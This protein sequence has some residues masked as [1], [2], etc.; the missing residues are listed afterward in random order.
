MA[1]NLLEVRNL[2]KAFGGVVANDAI[3]IDVPRGSIAG[4]IGPNGSGKTTLFG[5]IVG[6]HRVDTGSV[7]FDG[8]DISRLREPQIARLGLVRTFQQPEIYGGMTCIQNMQVSVPHVDADPR[9]MLAKVPPT[10]GGKAGELLDFV[11]LYEKRDRL[12]GE[13]SFGERKL[14]EFAMAL[15]NDPKMLLL[16]EPTAG[17]NPRRIDDV[18][19]RLRRANAALGVTLLVIEHNLRVVMDLAA[20]IYCLAHGQLLAAGT[21]AQIS[22]DPRVIQAYLGTR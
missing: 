11:G 19:D 6:Y 10:A 15:M 16:D 4:L 5:S 8:R 18:V 2:T 7:R 17:V 22:S 12:A 21:P 14:L 3:S 9:V 1:D 20:L 13:L